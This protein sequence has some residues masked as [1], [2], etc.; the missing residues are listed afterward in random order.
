MFKDKLGISIF[1]FYWCCFLLWKFKIDVLFVERLCI[2]YI[3]KGFMMYIVF[4]VEVKYW[5]WYVN[6][7]LGYNRFLE[8]IFKSW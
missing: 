8:R 6:D 3:L 1:L 7:V 4:L 5:F 2:I